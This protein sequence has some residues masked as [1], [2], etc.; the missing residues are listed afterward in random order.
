[1]GFQMIKMHLPLSS[2]VDID[3]SSLSL[4]RADLVFLEAAKHKS[5]GGGCGGE[6]W[7]GV[8]P[9]FHK[10]RVRLDGLAGPLWA[11]FLTRSLVYNACVNVPLYKLFGW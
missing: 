6:C 3:Q 7:W 5:E 1:M 2:G 11:L 4:L 9:F 8:S 10:D